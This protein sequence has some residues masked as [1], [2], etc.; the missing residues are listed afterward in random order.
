M[1]LRSGRFPHVFGAIFNRAKLQN[2]P[3]GDKV[4]ITLEFRIKK[5]EMT[6]EFTGSDTVRVVNR[7]KG[8]P[9]ASEELSVENY[10]RLFDQYD[11]DG[12]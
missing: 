1:I 4:P 3:I 6:Y 10:D 5:D 8:K 2:I 9:D 12:S 11:K 7:K